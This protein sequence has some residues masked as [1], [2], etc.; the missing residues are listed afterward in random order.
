MSAQEKFRQGLTAHQQGRLRE[1]EALYKQV[2]KSEPNHFDALH[3]AGV[4]ALQTDR[5]ERGI[6]LIQKALAL[7]PAAVSAIGNL[8]AGFYS[9]DRFEDALACFDKVIAL[10]PRDAGAHCNRGNALNGLKRFG[11]ALDAYDKA[12]TIEPRLTE[13]HVSRGNVLFDLERFADAVVAYD[14]AIRLE[15]RAV[16]ALSN[17]GNALARLDR[18]EEAL[19]SYDKAIAVAPGYPDAHYNRA[20]TLRHLSRLEDALASYDKAIAA[21][22]DFRAAHI[23]RGG[24][25]NDLGRFREA[26]ASYDTV[27][28]LNA[29]DAEAYLERG[30]TLSRAGLQD[31]A[32]TSFDRAVKLDPRNV[33][34]LVSRGSVLVGLKRFDEADESYSAAL[35]IDPDY[36]FLFGNWLSTKLYTCDWTDWDARVAE[37]ESRLKDGRKASAPFNLFAL[38]DDPDLQGRAAEAFTAA[39]VTRNYATPAISKLPRHDVLRIGY[40]S[41]DFRIHPVALLCAELFERHTRSRFQVTAFSFGPDTQDPMRKRLEA[42]F[43]KF[44][45]VRDK[46]DVAIASL[47]RELEI[48]IAIDL[49][50]MT[51]SSRPGIFAARAAPIQINYLGYPGTLGS[52]D[53][54]YLIAD[55]VTIPAAHRAYYREKIVALPGS[56]MPQDTQRTIADKLFSRSELGLPETGV[57]FCCFNASYK[58]NPRVFDCWMT[59]LKTTPGSVLWLADG[60]SMATANLRKEAAARDV[61][62][63]RLIFAGRT[64]T[65][66]EHLARYRAADLFLDTWPYNA[67]ATASDALWAGLPVLTRAGE[68]FPSC[69]GAS[70]VNAVGLD[71]LI[72]TTNDAYIAAATELA[73]QPDE[74]AAMRHK[75]SVNRISGQLFDMSSYVKHIEAAYRAMYDRYLSGAGPEHI[76]IEPL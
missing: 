72:T 7:D 46:S 4:I 61:D 5:A 3:L 54:D 23:N 69:V 59:I 51:Q 26:V 44:L 47:A 49:M 6:E 38:L 24:L 19:A 25:L 60:N 8:G 50:G 17:R 16:D 18:Y 12:L 36:D 75:L 37:L 53:I 70:L 9:L 29:R 62:P 39:R 15:N 71:E 2:L 42:A 35:A 31:D 66:D 30:K 22:P 10:R 64:E 20:K 13:A 63:S 21:K 74:L 11:D 68:A 76:Q 27:I 45:D 14:A 48:D 28:H 41:A 65:L 67:H 58:F 52:D 34:A 73:A 55:R 1:A 32:V 40:F 57:V 33:D 56:F 43:D